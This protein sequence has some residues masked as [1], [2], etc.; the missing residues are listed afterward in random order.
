MAAAHEAAYLAGMPK[1]E[2]LIT[3]TREKRAGVPV[4]DWLVERA[5]RHGKFEVSVTDLKELALP[6]LDEPG[7]P[8]KRQYQFEHT[9]RWSAIVAAADAFVFVVPEYNHGMPPALLN[10]LDYLFHEWNYKPAAFCAYG[11]QSG[12]IR[13]VEF[14]KSMLT[15]LKIMPIPEAVYFPFFSKQIT[16]GKFDPGPNPDASVNR[17]LDEL[18]RWSTA[19]RP[20]RTP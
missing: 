10:A 16:D 1:L 13:S 15:A 5:R 17:M 11:G 20:L 18:E 9:K 14:A 19:L 12:G 4:A 6:L 3:S 8:S 2:V 7:H